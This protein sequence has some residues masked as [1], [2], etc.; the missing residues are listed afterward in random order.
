M[1]PEPIRPV[2]GH[3]KVGCDGRWISIGTFADP[4]L[5]KCL[6]CKAT[7]RTRDEEDEPAPPE[8]MLQEAFPDPDAEAAQAK[9]PM[10]TW[11]QLLVVAAGTTLVCWAIWG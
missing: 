11:L 6:E 9:P 2:N 7:R 3:K 5:Q 4:L 10:P 1:A 8:P